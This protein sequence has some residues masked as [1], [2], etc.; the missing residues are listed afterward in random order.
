M[1]LDSQER[2]DVDGKEP[3]GLLQEFDEEVDVRDTMQR[4]QR[5][6]EMADQLESKLE[7]FLG[8]LKRMLS[9]L[10]PTDTNNVTTQ[11]KNTLE[12]QPNNNS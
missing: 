10:E 11:N 8:D 9:A 12:E 1:N 2:K 5:A 7:S 4:I 3:Q 6:E